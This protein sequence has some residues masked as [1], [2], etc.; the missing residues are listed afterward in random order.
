[1]QAIPGVKLVPPA[2]A[3]YAFPDVSAWGLDSITL[4]ERLLEQVGLAVV[5][6]IA[7][8]DDRCIR[9]SCAASPATI[10]DGL[11]RLE[12]CLASL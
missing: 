8:G 6:G 4:C 11:E 12:R 5:P 7:F 10:D 2:G 9:I 3:F 1:M